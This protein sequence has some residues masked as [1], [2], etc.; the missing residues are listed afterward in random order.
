MEVNNTKN[1]DSKLP[2]WTFAPSSK[3]SRRFQVRGQNPPLKLQ[4]VS[5]VPIQLL[6]WLLPGLVPFNVSLSLIKVY[7]LYIS[8]FGSN[9]TY[10]DLSY[11]LFANEK[12]EWLSLSKSILFSIP[13]LEPSLK[14]TSNGIGIP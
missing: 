4:Q 13:V 3:L 9:H 7:S 11:L 12:P 14:C 6:W 5:L 8:L 10:S 1:S 2:I